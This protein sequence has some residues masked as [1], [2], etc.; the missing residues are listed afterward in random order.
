MRHWA[1][2]M[3]MQSGTKIPVRRFEPFIGAAEFFLPFGVLII[4]S[5][6]FI[7]FFMI[8]G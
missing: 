8:Y 3:L 7:I 6:E 2:V 5:L 4:K 1:A